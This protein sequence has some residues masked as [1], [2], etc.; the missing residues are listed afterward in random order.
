MKRLWK[1]AAWPS[2]E[3]LLSA[4]WPVLTG[5]T[6][7]NTIAIEWKRAFGVGATD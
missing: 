2:L 3:G 7:T 4:Q 1:H 5:V 6:A